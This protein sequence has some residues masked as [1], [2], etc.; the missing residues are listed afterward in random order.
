MLR[1]GVDVGGTNTDAVLLLA[2]AAGN[3]ELL[4][5]AKVAMATFLLM[6]GTRYT[7]YLEQQE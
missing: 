3:V 1:V 2:R 7:N 4:A 6:Q 5:S